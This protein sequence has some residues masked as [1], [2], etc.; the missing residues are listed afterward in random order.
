[1][2]LRHKMDKVCKAHNHLPKQRKH[3]HSRPKT[4][5][6]TD[7]GASSSA[8]GVTEAPLSIS[9]LAKPVNTSSTDP[10]QIIYKAPSRGGPVDILEIP[11]SPSNHVP[12][13][14]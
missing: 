14:P 3:D 2:A 5:I 8:G 1:M 12:S 9:D 13:S 6:G 10:S 11:E 7:V 4:N